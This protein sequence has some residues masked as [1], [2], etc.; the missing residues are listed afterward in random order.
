M[1]LTSIDPRTG[2]I[3]ALYGGEDY[4]KSQVNSATQAVAQA[5]STYKPFALVT[6]LNDGMTLSDGYM[7]TSPMTI[8]GHEFQ[9]FQ[10]VS[11]GWVNLVKATAFSINTP[12]CN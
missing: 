10:D 1:A 3:V 2:A 6:A 9:N 11:Y 5:G 7:G 8:E 12:T 4:L